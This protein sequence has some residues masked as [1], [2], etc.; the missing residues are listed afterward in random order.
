MIAFNYKTKI[1][2]QGISVDLQLDPSP[3]GAGALLK[4]TNAKADGFNFFGLVKKKAVQ[5]IKQELNNNKI[6]Y[7]EASNDSVY[8]KLPN[9]VT[10]C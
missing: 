6:A 9:G 8:L 1:A 2:G 7:V 4:V 10:L 3:T 5:V